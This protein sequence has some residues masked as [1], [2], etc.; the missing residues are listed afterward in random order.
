MRHSRARGQSLVEFAIVVPIFLLLLFGLIDFSRLLFTYIS[1]ANGTRELA[2]VAALPTTTSATPSAPVSAFNNL[3]IFGGPVA[4]GATQITFTNSPY[5]INCTIGATGCQ[6]TLST[7]KGTPNT[8]SL[9]SA[10]PA[11]VSYTFA[12]APDPSAFTATANGDYVMVT[13]IS[14]EVGGW[15]G[16]VRICP[17]P[18]TASCTLGAP[19]SAS[20]GLID[21][22]VVHNFRFNPLFENKL[23]GVID[24]SFMRPFS[25]LQTST[26]TYVE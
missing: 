8:T 2:R 10:L 26:R 12:A 4:S 20:D 3:T 24:A 5:S 11:T 21:V 17:L 23:S 1:L 16:T 18:L 14:S 6:L 25:V 22:R 7:I 9:T 13:S 15:N 19:A